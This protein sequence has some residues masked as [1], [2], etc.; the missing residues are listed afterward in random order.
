M[1]FIDMPDR[2]Y[3]SES[4]LQ[5]NVVKWLKLV[6]PKPSIFHHSP[7]EGRNKVQWYQKLKTMGFQTGWPDLEIFVENCRPIFIE[8]K[9]PRNYMSIFQKEIK[10]KLE[11][12]A[13]VFV[14]RSL[15]ECEKALG[16]HMV[17]SPN[18]Y[19]KAMIEAEIML[20]RQIIL[21]KEKEKQ[22]RRKLRKLTVMN[23]KEAEQ[24]KW[25]L[26]LPSRS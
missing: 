23:K 2:V 24:N 9:Q 5:K 10:E 19:A 7:G 11:N 3:A 13:Y 6:L 15:Q 17:L 26:N 25:K 1:I 12:F 4:D 16:K 22:N 18:K 8:L 14:C 21:D 20:E